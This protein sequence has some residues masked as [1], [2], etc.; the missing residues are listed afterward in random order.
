MQLTQ[1]LATGPLD[2]LRILDLGCGEGV[3]AIEA[4]LRGADVLAI[5]A[6]DERMREGAECAARHGLRNVRFERGDARELSAERAGSFD[7]VYCLGLLYHLDAPE[8]F[9]FLAAVRELCA[10]ALIVDTLISLEPDT[11]VT[12]LDRAYRGERTREHGDDDPPA[13]RQQRL[14]RSI[15]STFAFRFTRESLV[16][17]LRVRGSPPCSS[18]T[19]RRSRV[20]P[21]TGSRSRPPAPS[22]CESRPIRGSRGSVSARSCAG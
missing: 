19:P 4:G 16:R 14:L 15:D 20:R 12:Y 6:R 7:I 13:V 18:V 1:D 3:Y 5:D 21:R 8:V 2:Q 10:G 17:A 22:R 9:P 11:E